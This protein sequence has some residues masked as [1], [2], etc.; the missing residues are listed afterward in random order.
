MAFVRRGSQHTCQCC[1]VSSLVHTGDPIHCHQGHTHTL[2]LYP[3]ELSI[4]YA[5]GKAISLVQVGPGAHTKQLQEWQE[6]LH[7]QDVD[8]QRSMLY[9]TDDRGTLLRVVGH[10][11]RREAIT[12]GLPGETLQGDGGHAQL[13]SWVWRIAVPWCPH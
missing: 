7:L 4:V 10:P 6:S 2:P 3:A 12:T 5:S 11:G 1:Y 13:I 9:G 8:W